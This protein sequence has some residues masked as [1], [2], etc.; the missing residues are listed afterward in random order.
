MKHAFLIIAH[1]V[2]L[3]LITLLKMLD[4]KRN[5]IF[6]HMDK[7]NTVFNQSILPDM[8]YSNLVLTDRISVAWG[9]GILR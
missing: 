8:K 2:D 7:K 9:G 6:L 4:H 5:D 3:T 1:K